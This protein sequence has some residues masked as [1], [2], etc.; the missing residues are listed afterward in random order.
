VAELG[1]DFGG[2]VDLD[3]A[4]PVVAGRLCL[5]QALARRLTTPAGSLLGDPNYGYD[6][7]LLLNAPFN[8]AF[9]EARITDECLKD[10]RVEDVDVTVSFDRT[11]STVTVAIVVTPSADAVFEFTLNVSQLRVELLV[12]E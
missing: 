7:R 4:M 12:G 5:A 3:P 9:V 1:S 11:T 8:A 6:T 2:V 10:E